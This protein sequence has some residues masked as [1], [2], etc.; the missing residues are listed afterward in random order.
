MFPREKDEGC[1]CPVPVA[2]SPRPQCWC[3][4]FLLRLR[5]TLAWP[6]PASQLGWRWLAPGLREVSPSLSPSFLVFKKG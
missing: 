4:G 6:P 3:G 5:G 1:G 2:A